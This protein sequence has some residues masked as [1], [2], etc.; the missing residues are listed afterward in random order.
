MVD[1]I[2]KIKVEVIIVSWVFV[3]RYIWGVSFCFFGLLV[4]L[5]LWVVVFWRFGEWWYV[6]IWCG[7]KGFSGYIVVMM[8][9]GN[10]N[11]K[12]EGSKKIIVRGR[13]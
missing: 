12:L 3:Y 6:L 9:V 7:G 13:N 1:K 4:L 11:M 5:E 2:G 8:L 10:V